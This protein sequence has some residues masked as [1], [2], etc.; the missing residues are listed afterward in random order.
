[1]RADALDDL[2][3]VISAECRQRFGLKLRPLSGRR[4]DQVALQKIDVAERDDHDHE[5]QDADDQDRPLIE[6]AE[7]PVP[8]RAHRADGVGR[9]LRGGIHHESPGKRPQDAPDHGCRDC[10]RH[11]RPAPVRNIA[12]RNIGTERRDDSGCSATRRLSTIAAAPIY[13]S[14]WSARAAFFKASTVDPY[15]GT[16]DFPDPF[17]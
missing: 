10:A 11:G 2:R 17:E 3:R 13:W 8:A 1:M 6:P 16:P 15:Q 7:Q 14:R 9:I 12:V 4:I 5:E